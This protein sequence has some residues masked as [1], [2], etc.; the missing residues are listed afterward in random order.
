ME[1]VTMKATSARCP[2]IAERNATKSLTP[3]A[4]FPFFRLDDRVGYASFALIAI[5]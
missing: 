3:A 2:R 5:V 1:G 4:I